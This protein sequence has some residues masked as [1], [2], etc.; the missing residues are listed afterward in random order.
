MERPRR[1]HRLDAI[2]RG[3]IVNTARKSYWRVAG[4]YD[5]D[6]LIQDGYICY[7][8]CHEKYPAELNRRN[9]M[10]LVQRTFQNHI[11]KLA[12][13]K[14]R[15][16]DAPLDSLS[17]AES[18]EDHLDALSLPD[19]EEQMFNVLVSELPE[20]FRELVRILMKDHE[21]AMSRPQSTGPE[22]RNAWLCRIAGIDPGTDV[23]GVFREHFKA[24]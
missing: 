20:K 6:D 22:T 24:A 7:L 17:L 19:H 15:Q 13:T 12:I 2:M 10:A 5:L 21:L 23:E 11:N 3:W 16:L 18:V 4:W 9:F 1:T 8:K 14:S